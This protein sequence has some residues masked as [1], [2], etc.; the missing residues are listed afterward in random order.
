MK[1]FRHSIV[2]LLVVA[3][4][5]A[6]SMGLVGCQEEEDTQPGKEHPASSK[7]KDHPAH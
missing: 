4:I 7:P 1:K 2:S 3:A 6:L 5:A